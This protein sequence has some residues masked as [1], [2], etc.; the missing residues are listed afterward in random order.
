M[1]GIRFA[2]PPLSVLITEWPRRDG[3]LG[4]VGPGGT[5]VQRIEIVLA[6]DHAVIRGGLR[7][8][9]DAETDFSVVAEA[10][11]EALGDATVTRAG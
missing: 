9:L 8:V 10:A 7:Q 6:D 11:L 2:P 4:G 5:A 1:A 3:R